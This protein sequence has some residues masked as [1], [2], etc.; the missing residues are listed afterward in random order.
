MHFG[1]VQMLSAVSTLKQSRTSFQSKTPEP[2][3]DEPIAYRYRVAQAIVG[4]ARLDA[5]HRQGAPLAQG[6]MRARPGH[7]RR[8]ELL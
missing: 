3:E 1:V 4:K 7:E 6:G 2:N 8:P 5:L